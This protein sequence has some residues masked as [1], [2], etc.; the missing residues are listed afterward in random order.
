MKFSEYPSNWRIYWIE[1]VLEFI[2]AN[3]CIQ[4]EFLFDQY[5]VNYNLYN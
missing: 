3:V 4:D 2:T 1:P 5:S